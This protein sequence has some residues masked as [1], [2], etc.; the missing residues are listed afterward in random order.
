MDGY[1]TLQSLSFINDQDYRHFAGDAMDGGHL[2]GDRPA[3]RTD[4]GLE[5]VGQ[6]AGFAVQQDGD[7][8]RV[9]LARV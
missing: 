6:F 4:D 3:I 1:E 9:G 2:V 8:H 7:V 5:V